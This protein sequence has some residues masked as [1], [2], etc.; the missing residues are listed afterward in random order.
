M[1]ITLYQTLFFRIC[2]RPYSILYI[3]CIPLLTPHQALPSHIYKYLCVQEIFAKSIN[4][5]KM[6]NINYLVQTEYHINA[7]NRHTSK[8]ST[9]CPL[10]G[11]I[12]GKGRIMRLNSQ[13]IFAYNMQQLL[14]IRG[15]LK[16][17]YVEDIEQPIGTKF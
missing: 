7:F 6:S 3:A 15:T 2:I 5:S 16:A 17:V 11:I 9:R 10:D 14:T 1:S 4:Q 8:S 12:R 13:P